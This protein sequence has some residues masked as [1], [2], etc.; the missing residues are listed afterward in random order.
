MS[1]NTITGASGEF[2]VAAYLSALNLVVAL[3]R[4]GVPSSDLLVT[5][6]RGEKTISLQVK[7]A[8]KS[9]NPSKDHGD[10]LAWEMPNKAITVSDTHWYAFVDIKNWPKDDKTPEVFLV[11][12]AKVKFVFETEN[13]SD[14]ERVFTL[15]SVKLINTKDN[16]AAI[17][18]LNN[19]KSH[20][21]TPTGYLRAA[22]QFFG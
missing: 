15:M 2:F 10:Y 7:T 9:F 11:P 21:R 16:K 3:P 12:S 4:G 5:T 22:E 13:K 14:A 17:V 20:H 6:E 19:Y 18:W 8:K 1:N